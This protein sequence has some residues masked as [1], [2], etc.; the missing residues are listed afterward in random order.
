MNKLDNGMNLDGMDIEE[1]TELAAKIKVAEQSAKERYLS[2]AKELAATLIEKCNALG[3]KVTSFFRE[4]KVT[5]RYRN[6]DNPDETWKGRG[7]KPKW[8][9]KALEGLSEEEAELKL[10]SYRIQQ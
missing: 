4:E 1:L 8:L 5:H 2:E 9:K 7:P 3:L 6:T 10:E